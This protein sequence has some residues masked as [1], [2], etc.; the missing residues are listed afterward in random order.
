MRSIMKR[1]Q[2]LSKDRL[3]EAKD[4]A[5]FAR[6]KKVKLTREC[7]NPEKSPNFPIQ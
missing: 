2:F 7:N 4:I 6:N 5:Y 3:D 1:E